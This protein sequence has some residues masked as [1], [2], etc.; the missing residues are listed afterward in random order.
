MSGS[1]GNVF[2][3]LSKQVRL[4]SSTPVANSGQN[5]VIPQPTVTQ[6]GQ[7]LDPQGNI[8][9]DTYQIAVPNGDCSVHLLVERTA[10][11]H[12]QIIKSILMDGGND[13]SQ[14]AVNAAA[15]LDESL[16]V[17]RARYDPRG[18][19]KI[20]F[21]AWIVTHWDNDHWAGSLQMFRN[22]MDLHGRSSRMKYDGRIPLTCLYCPN[23]TG[24]P[25]YPATSITPRADLLKKRSSGL[26]IK[27]D[28]Q[29]DFDAV[30]EGDVYFV[31]NHTQDGYPLCKA[32]WGHRQLL[33][34][35]FFT[36][37]TPWHHLQQTMD[38]TA[39]NARQK[40]LN[41]FANVDFVMQHA[42]KRNP[43][44]PRFVCIGV[45][46]FV[47]GA[48]L[49]ITALQSALAARK[50]TQ[51]DTWANLSSI[52]SVL[53]FPNQKQVSL[54]W[55]GDSITPIELPLANSTFFN[56][57]TCAVAK[58]SHHG[59]RHSSPDKLWEKLRP[60]SCVVSPNRTGKYL[61]P[62]P[63]TITRFRAYALTQTAI[64]PKIYST[65][66]PGW[67]LAPT[68]YG[69]KKI[70]EHG[71]LDQ[72]QEYWHDVSHLQ[73][74]RIACPTFV[75]D[76]KTRTHVLCENGYTPPPKRGRP[77]SKRSTWQMQFIHI[78]SSANTNRDGT[79]RPFAA[80]YKSAKA[81]TISAG[82]NAV[83]VL[84]NAA[85][86]L[87]NTA[88]ALDNT[89]VVIDD[90]SDAE[91]DRYDVFIDD[92]VEDE[93]WASDL[94]DT[95]RQSSTSGMRIED[96]EDARF[97]PVGNPEL[98]KL[99]EKLEQLRLLRMIQQSQSHQQQQQQQ[100]QQS[101]LQYQSQL[102]FQQQYQP[103]QV[104]F[105][106][107]PQYQQPQL[108]YQ[109]SQYQQSQFQYQQ[110]YQQ[111]QYQQPQYQYQQYQQFQPYTQNL[112]Y[113]QFQPNEQFPPY[114]PYQPNQ[115]NQQNQQGYGGRQDLS[116]FDYRTNY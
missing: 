67:I 36:G 85:S 14:S 58:W 41:T 97:G 111:P 103:S 72:L 42:N 84:N 10:V 21:D 63:A 16:E 66:Y 15:I 38:L 4:I 116:Q 23:W 34:L 48:E 53:H 108:Q 37:D 104:F 89:I 13:G 52:M 78:L 2:I 74:D 76:S 114:Q 6:P 35:D 93:Q 27:G 55:G 3:G 25:K 33:G 20:Q 98:L 60:K 50:A 61:H 83:P 80:P 17:I 70:A 95:A 31:S 71:G 46:G 30:G 113:Q 47:F 19:Q 82:M 12:G 109:Q 73:P 64:K 96:E 9:V 69:H 39:D 100:Q 7:D 77:S 57:Y 28:D 40:V 79:I 32:K 115:Q 1:V 11:L 102:Q 54:Y 8:E 94:D 65:F 75:Y 22:N 107:Q 29:P 110:Q 44:F 91:T 56:G 101:M 18:L 88:P 49:D 92:S 43:K 45:G 59:G 86:M 99:A 106:Q 68:N 81:T 87:N 105:Q 51:D 24:L 26:F 90:D 62:H 5:I 112:L